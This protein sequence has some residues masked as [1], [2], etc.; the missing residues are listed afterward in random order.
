MGIDKP[1]VRYV[2]HAS[3]PKSVEGYYQESG[4]AGRDGEI[5]HCILFYSY[6][7]VHRIKRIISS[8]QMLN[9]PQC[10]EVPEHSSSCLCFHLWTVDR[11]GDGH[12]KATHYN[13]LHSMV[14]FCEN[15]MECRRIQLLAYFGELKFNRSFCKEHTDV[16]CDNCARPNVGRPPRPFFPR[17]CCRQNLFLIEWFWFLCVQKYKLRNVTDDVKKI[18]RFVQENC[19]KVGS[20]FGKTS[21]QNRLT[22]NMLV[23]IFLGQIY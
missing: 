8:E 15:A 11:E 1:D 4:R 6:T 2:I 22:L 13:N 18:V 5:S 10:R 17:I 16:S 9:L 12:S 7:D 19:E 23:D 3:L 20:R 14:H 21:Q